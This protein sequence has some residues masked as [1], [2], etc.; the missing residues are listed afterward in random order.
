M[1]KC[2]ICQIELID[3]GS[4]FADDGPPCYNGK[5]IEYDS[6][7]IWVCDKCLNEDNDNLQNS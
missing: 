4:P 1:P 5:A 7:S 6:E 3:E 2:A